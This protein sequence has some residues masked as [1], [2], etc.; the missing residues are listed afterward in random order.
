MA[1]G[2]VMLRLEDNRYVQRVGS[3]HVGSQHVGS[4]HAGMDVCTSLGHTVALLWGTWPVPLFWSLLSNCIMGSITTN[5]L[6][7]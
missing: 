3:Q 4:Q 2:I 6:L 1:A 7:F 5:P